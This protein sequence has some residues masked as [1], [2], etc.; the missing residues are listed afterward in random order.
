[1]HLLFAQRSDGQTTLHAPQLNGSLVVSTQLPLQSVRPSSHWNASTMTS[2]GV[3][4]LGVVSVVVSLVTT[5]PVVASPASASAPSIA[6]SSDAGTHL[7]PDWTY[8]VAHSPSTSALSRPQ[9]VM[10]VS[11]TSFF[12]A[13]LAAW[14]AARVA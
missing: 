10:R 11:H 1:M 4:S 5:S 6:P 8:P 14:S 7:S 13:L 2:L 12:M 3:T 9:A